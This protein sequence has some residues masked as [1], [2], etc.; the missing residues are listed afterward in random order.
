MISSLS[1]LSQVDRHCREIDSSVRD[2]VWVTTEWRTG[3]PIK[4]LDSQIEGSYKILERVGNAYKLDLP[5][6]EIKVDPD[7]ARLQAILS[8][9]STPTL[10][11]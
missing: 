9:D 3:C 4:K 11:L 7:C 6:S 1:S 10:R 2:S 5:V 8:L